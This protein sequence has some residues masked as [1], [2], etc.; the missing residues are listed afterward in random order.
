MNHINWLRPVIGN[1][2]PQPV[3]RAGKAEQQQTRISPRETQGHCRLV[4]YTIGADLLVQEVAY[5]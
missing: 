5:V 3:F 4:A 2:G 1:D